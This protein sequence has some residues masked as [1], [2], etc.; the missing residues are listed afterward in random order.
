MWARNGDVI[1][2][3]GLYSRVITPSELQVSIPETYDSLGTLETIVRDYCLRFPFLENWC[4]ISAYRGY[5]KS[6][7]NFSNLDKAG[8]QEFS[9]K[10]FVKGEMGTTFSFAPPGFDVH[11][12]PR[13]DIADIVVPLT[14][15]F[16]DT[17]AYAIEPFEGLYLSELSLYYLGMFLLSSLVRYRP[18][19]WGHALS[20]RATSELPAD[21]STLTLIERFMDLS[22]SVFPKAI[23]YAISL[24]R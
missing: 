7:L 10:S 19:I 18:E 20:R 1:G 22:L 5:Q 24:S 21:D 15:G 11:T 4:L 16:R 23:V 3:S 2:Q 6:T 14:R 9:E 13:R 8:I 12:H 17:T